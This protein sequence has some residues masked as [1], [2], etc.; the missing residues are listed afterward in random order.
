MSCRNVAILIFDDVEILDFAGPYQVFATTRQHDPEPPFFVYTVAEK[1][2]PVSA[3]NGLS[4]NPYLRLPGS[5][6]CAGPR[7]TRH[8]DACL[9]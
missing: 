6:H 8:A 1:S 5:R 4:V 2:K 9:Q 7:R 3:R